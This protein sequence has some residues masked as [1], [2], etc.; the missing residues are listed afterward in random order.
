MD[1]HGG[2]GGGAP[3]AEGIGEL[4][5]YLAILRGYRKIIAG[6]VGAT[7]LLGFVFA[8]VRSPKYTAE[9]QLL[10]P[11]T[12]T[13][14]L[15]TMSNVMSGSILG[16]GA[17]GGALGGGIFEKKSTWEAIL[18]SNTV[19]SAIIKRFGLEEMY[20][21]KTIKKTRKALEKNLKIEI[22]RDKTLT[23]DFRDKDPVLAAKIAN[24]FGEELDRV[25]KNILMTSGKKA[26]MFIEQRL[27]EVDL[28]LN[29]ALDAIKEF[30]EKNK[31]IDI[32]KQTSSAFVTIATV[33]AQKI[34]MEAK[35]EMLLT[36]Y[37][38]NSREVEGVRANI[39]DLERQLNQLEE[40]GGGK[41]STFIPT[42][43]VPELGK[44]FAL[45][46]MEAEIQK[47]VLKFLNQEYELS[48]I[49]ES[50]DTP[51][52]QI[53]DVATVPEKEDSD[54]D[55]KT[56]IILELSLFGSLFLS[57]G[58]ALLHHSWMNR[59]QFQPTVDKKH[60]WKKVDV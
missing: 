37:S 32:E 4:L 39:R 19:E 36:L 38:T 6:V 26:R 7:F 46:L 1:E 47:N 27:K 31:A 52:V 22:G 55:S 53:L 34:T 56:F 54:F 30:Q 48:K 57:C 35:L 44:K 23:L 13:G 41:A 25:N 45:L 11:D 42:S 16:A 12:S 18:K 58:G 15:G 29:A 60:R 40:G 8:L 59:K 17:M 43:K 51:T 5:Q 10:P 2:Q 28:K 49:Q 9:I 3:D 20:R 14:V 33:K 50:Q 21:T 24:A